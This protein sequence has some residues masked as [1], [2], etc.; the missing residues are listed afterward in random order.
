MTCYVTNNVTCGYSS[1][2]SVT[3]TV[4][5][6]GIQQLAGA[7]GII[8]T[9]NP[10]NGI[11]TIRGNLSNGY[12]GKTVI[13]ITNIFG[14]VIY[15]NDFPENN[16]LLNQ[17]VQIDFSDIPAGLYFAKINGSSVQKFVKI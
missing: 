15:R 7:S 17:G 8:V 12:N 2:N 1:F 16:T 11:F 3:M 14:Q 6:T 9:P 13:E 10:N 4:A 5:A